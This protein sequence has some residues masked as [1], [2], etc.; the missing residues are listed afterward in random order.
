MTF[1]NAIEFKKTLPEKIVIS[2]LEYVAMVVPE[3][4]NDLI[5]YYKK[6]LH[7]ECTDETAIEFSSN[8]NYEVYGIHISHGM[9][10]MPKKLS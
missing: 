9:I 8:R 5:E 7:Y 2:D 3:N 10:I 4:K 1:E 6:Y